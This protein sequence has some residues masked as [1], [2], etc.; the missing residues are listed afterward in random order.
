MKVKFVIPVIYGT[1]YL[2]MERDDIIQDG[3]LIPDEL[4]FSDDKNMFKTSLVSIIFHV[5][6][7]CY[8]IKCKQIMYRCS[9]EAYDSDMKIL[10]S[11]GFKLIKG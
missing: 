9:D 6:K 1:E 5:F 10:E 7:G 11:L 4:D 8:I 3:G 2:R